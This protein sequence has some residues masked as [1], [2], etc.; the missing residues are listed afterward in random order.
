MGEFYSNM[1]GV[2]IRRDSDTH[3]QRE[4]HVRGHMDKTAVCQARREAQG[5]PALLTVCLGLLVSRT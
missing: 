3:T 1:T 5:T 4:E 2:M